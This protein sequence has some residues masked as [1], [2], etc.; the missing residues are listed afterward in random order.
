MQFPSTEPVNNY[1]FYSEVTLF[2]VKVI[3]SRAIIS[4]RNVRTS[5]LCLQT[6]RLVYNY[7]LDPIAHKEKPSSHYMRSINKSAMLSTI[8]IK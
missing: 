3:I 1:L 6:M 4:V 8:F 5:C 2:I 7:R